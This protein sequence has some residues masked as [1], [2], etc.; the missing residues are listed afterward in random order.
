MAGLK[1]GRH[2]RTIHTLSVDFGRHDPRLVFPAGK[3]LGS[4]SNPAFVSTAAQSLR[5]G[6]DP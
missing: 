6:R 1:H 2:N 3:A 5:G 4:P